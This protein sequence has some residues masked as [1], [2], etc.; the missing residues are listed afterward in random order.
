[1]FIAKEKRKNNIGEY[2]LYMYQIEDLIRA[3]KLDHKIIEDQLISRYNVESDS[4]QEI[5][6]W[7]L[8]L[9]E[10]MHEEQLHKKGH[11]SF[12]TNKINELQ[13]FHKYLLQ[14][15]DNMDYVSIY[16]KCL[17][18]LNEIIAKQ[19]NATNEIQS[20]VD[21]I[22]G[23]F[24][25]KLKNETISTETTESIMLLTKLLAKLSE[26]FKGYE[27]GSLKIEI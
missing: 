21:V 4:L 5:K 25:L 13:D 9:A 3:C 27:E 14:S 23:Y 24:L 12:I 26:K 11:L 16:Q 22:Y 20:V 17:P 8:G 18:L 1:M 7:Y 19:P 2:L 10:L 6:N 15:K